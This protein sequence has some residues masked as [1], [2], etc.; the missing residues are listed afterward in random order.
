M[1][2]TNDHALKSRVIGND[3]ARFGIGGDGSDPS[4][5]H[6]KQKRIMVGVHPITMKNG[7]PALR[8]VCSIC[9]TQIIRIGSKS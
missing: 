3:H 8:G 6:K 2:I 5:D 7:R 9:K 4:A 1:S